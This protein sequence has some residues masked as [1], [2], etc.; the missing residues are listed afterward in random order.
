MSTIVIDAELKEKLIAAGGT[1]TLS[2]P[3][4][5]RL[6]RFVPSLELFDIPELDLTPE[7]L[8]RALSPDCKT[9]TTQE[10]LAYCKGKE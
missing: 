4:G 7:E 1:V 9:Y 2:D 3:A 5:K 10:V 8:E 6:G